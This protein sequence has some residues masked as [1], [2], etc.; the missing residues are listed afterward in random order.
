MKVDGMKIAKL[1]GNLENVEGSA[2]DQWRTAR[3]ETVRENPAEKVGRRDEMVVEVRRK[4]SRD[5][6]GGG[7]VYVVNLTKSGEEVGA[8]AK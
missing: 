6:S 1:P 4:E 3:R 5:A 8:G 2:Y 7:W